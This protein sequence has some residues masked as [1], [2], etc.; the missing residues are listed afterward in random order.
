[1]ARSLLISFSFLGSLLAG[2]AAGAQDAAFHLD[3][4]GDAAFEGT[5]G[6]SQSL[7]FS[8]TL[9]SGAAGAQAWT[10]SI[11]ADGARIT[12]ITVEGT[13][14]P[15]LLNSGFVKNEVTSG[16]GNEGA[17]SSVVL[18]AT[19]PDTTLPPNS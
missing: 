16:P 6:S 9:E 4:K 14:V 1:M 10:L 19:N 7:K 17:I 15:N 12:A 5:P 3:F 13:V 8:A 11:R 18:S 2:A